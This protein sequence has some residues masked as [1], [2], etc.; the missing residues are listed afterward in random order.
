MNSRILKAHLALFGAQCMWGLMSP[1]GKAAMTAGISGMSLASMRMIGAAICFWIA[2]MF[3]PKE[4]VSRKDFVLLFFAALFSIVF[5]QGLFI[6]GL[7]LTSPVNA[8]IV[9]TSLPI[10]TL[11]LAA[12]FLKEPVTLKKVSGVL[13]GGIG[14][15]MLIFTSRSG[16]AGEGNIIGDLMCIGAQISFAFYLTFFKGLITRYNIF[17]IMKWMFTYGAICFIPVSF[18]D[19]SDMFSQ[20]FPTE[21][22]LEVAYVVVFGTFLAYL[23]VIIGQKGVRPTI[24]SM[25]NYV[26]PLVGATVSIIIGMATF[27]WLKGLAAVLVFTGVYIVTQSR[28]R[29]QK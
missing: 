25:Y 22:W 27:S 29:E 10:F 15:L 13:I 17:T 6:F 1:I 20:N 8:P 16:V 14:A 5:N 18:N 11:L 4:K 26:Q 21:V 12:L 2:S 19:L 24:V 23:L 7:S 28:S 3:A 9:T